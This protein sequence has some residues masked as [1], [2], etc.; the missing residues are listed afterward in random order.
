[1]K[2][3]FATLEMLKLE[4]CTE[5]LTSLIDAAVDKNKKTTIYTNQ[6]GEWRPYLLVIP[7][8]PIHQIIRINPQ[9]WEE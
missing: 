3:F 5:S 4:N 2:K 1:M 6:S 9:S 7:T 8:K